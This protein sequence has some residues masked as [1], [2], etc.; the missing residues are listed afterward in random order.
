MYCIDHRLF[1]RDL[2]LLAKAVT[3]GLALLLGRYCVVNIVDIVVYLNIKGG[4]R[5]LDPRLLI[6]NPIDDDHLR[7]LLLNLF[8]RVIGF[9]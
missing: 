1:S 3:S 9:A 6:L 5:D 8:V 4:F 2:R 7:V